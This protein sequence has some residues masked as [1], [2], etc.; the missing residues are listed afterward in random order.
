LTLRY[1]S[2]FFD[3]FPHPKCEGKITF[4]HASPATGQGPIAGFCDR[5]QAY[6]AKY[7]RSS[8]KDRKPHGGPGCRSPPLLKFWLFKISEEWRYCLMAEDKKYR[9]RIQDTL[10]DVTEEVYFTYYRMER[11]TKTL[12]EKDER[13]GLVSYDALDNGELIGEEAI[14]TPDA[15]GVEDK[16]I[17]M[18]LREKLRQCMTSLS[19]SERDLL[20]ALYFE[21]LTERQLAKRIGKHYMTIHNRKVKILSELK[22]LIES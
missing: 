10:V 19:E 16:V 5:W 6:I 15:V 17:D 18:L 13:N 4:P 14:T 20:Y 11:H 1:F 12:D 22:K 3:F 8:K 7:P 9:I 21:G 2:P